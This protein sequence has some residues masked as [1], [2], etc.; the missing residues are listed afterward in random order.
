MIQPT[1]VFVPGLRDHMPDHWQTI[2]QAKLPRTACVPR[3]G[4][5]VLSCAAWVEVLD[6]TVEGVE[7]PIVFAAHSAGV[8]MVAHWAQ[9][10][11][12]A[13]AGALLAAPPDFESPLPAGYPSRETLEH[14]GWIPTPRALLPFPSIVAAST[15]DPL[16]TYARAASF[17]AA[18]GSELVN[19][20]AVGHLNPSSGFGEWP[21]AMD[22]LRDFGVRMTAAKV[23][24][25]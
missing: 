11:R 17:A 16:S 9:R 14:H 3:L 18:W 7:G 24:A 2:L 1:V 12:R 10:E 21:R 19:V 22:L 8:M 5:E 6:A 15:N 13:I 4:K 20:G 25:Y 23:A